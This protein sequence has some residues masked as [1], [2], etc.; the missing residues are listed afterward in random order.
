MTR[1]P[2]IMILT[3]ALVLSACSTDV[4]LI[5]AQQ[6][7]AGTL[8]QNT[9]YGWKN[10]VVGP[11]WRIKDED[12]RESKAVTD[13]QKN[14]PMLEV[15]PAENGL[16]EFTRKQLL[17]NV[18]KHDGWSSNFYTFATLDM[19]E[20]QLAQIA[21]VTAKKN[22]IILIRGLKNESVADT[23]E[24]AR[25]FTDRGLKVVISPALSEEFKVK[26]SP[27]FIQTAVSADGSYG[28]P[29]DAENCVPYKGLIG[30]NMDILKVMLPLH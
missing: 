30:L 17:A 18:V 1:N 25:F 29:G 28:C 19:K 27:T 11:S 24:A 22:G 2:I 6:V 16:R 8:A 3:G 4:A 21:E 12:L 10:T 9:V 20:K 5:A 7:I 26:F 15:V 13:E 23:V 14:T